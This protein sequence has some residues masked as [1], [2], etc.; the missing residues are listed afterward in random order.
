M[1]KIILI[2]LSILLLSACS[3][4]NDKATTNSELFETI[5]LTNEAETTVTDIS[6]YDDN[7]GVICGTLGFFAK[8]SDG[9]KSW[10]KLNIGVNHSFLSTF[11]LDINTFYTARLGLYKTSNSG[12]S[13]NDIGNL[14]S[15]SSSVFNIYFSNNSIGF[16]T[17]NGSIKKTID[18]GNTW[19]GKYFASP[20]YGIYDLKFTSENIG[21]GSGGNR[22][23]NFNEGQIVKTT[24]GGET[25][26]IILMTTNINSISFISDNVGFYS[27]DNKE[28]FK[29]TDGGVSWNNISTLQY[30]PIDILFQNNKIGYVATYEGKILI[31]KDGGN[32]WQVVY[33]KTNVP[34]NKIIKTSN[35]IF[36]VGNNGL[37]IKSNKI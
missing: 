7:N 34:I 29:T 22:F 13:F 8:T 16:I 5:E 14:S 12:S 28:I 24:D 11:M 36:A 15:I 35:Y 4:E 17:H 37:L 25:W 32:T 21:Y 18:G 23:D 31:T 6:F 26:N 3:K 33:D 2:L 30:Y 10:K 27:N 20:Y 9:G 1:K 19:V